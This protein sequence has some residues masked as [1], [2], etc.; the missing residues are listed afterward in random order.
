MRF[1]IFLNVFFLFINTNLF[2]EEVWF[3]SGSDNSSDKYFSQNQINKNNIHLLV[4]EWEFHS[5]DVGDN[6]ANPIL[7]GKYLITVGVNSGSVIAIDPSNGQLQWKRTLPGYPG[8]RGMTSLANTVF[9]PTHDGI[10]ALDS[11]SGEIDKKYGNSGQFGHEVSLLPPVIIDNTII[12][13]NL[14]SVQSFDLYTGKENWKK[15]LDKDNVSP[16]IW[17]GISYDKKTNLIFIVTSNA[18]GLI[19]EDI[20]SGGYSSSL[21]SLNALNGNIV[22]QIQDIKHDLWDLDVVGA[23]IVGDVPIKGTLV[24]AV[25][26]VTKTGKVIFADAK[27]GKLIFGGNYT[28]INEGVTK[29]PTYELHIKLPENFSKTDFDPNIDISELSDENK[30]YVKFRIRNAK[31][32]H[33]VPITNDNDSVL[34]GLHGGAEWPGAA[35]N[36]PTNILIIPSNHNPWI[37]RQRFFDKNDEYSTKNFI[38]NK[39]YATK[40]LVCHGMN[41]KGWHE[42]EGLGDKYY[43]SLI[44]ISNNSQRFKN[45]SKQNF[46]SVH[47]YAKESELSS[48]NIDQNNAYKNY[49]IEKVDNYLRKLSFLPVKLMAHAKKLLHKINN[50]KINLQEVNNG[51]NNITNNEL[52]DLKQL[53]ILNDREVTKRKDLASEGFWQLLLTKE[54]LPASNPPW[55]LLTGIEMSSGKKKWEIPFGVQKMNGKLVQGDIN[56]GGILSLS[57]IFFAGGTRDK[58][59]RAY[60]VKNGKEI[61]SSELPA[62]SSSPPMTYYFKGCQHILVTATGGTF[63]GFSHADSTI[64]YKLKT[65]RYK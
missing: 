17:S 18:N 2:S 58:F 12:S 50:D 48:F 62:A 40:C 55:G 37:L 24:H 35:L 42:W 3:R 14:T 41:G 59:I 54:K 5:G 49:Q 51:I 32:G 46:L 47:R 15:L 13:A 29:Q 65:C 33:L 43:P 31:I 7:V 22:W 53:I 9:V 60:D 34:F 23:P 6:Q 63:I 61:W 21:I 28:S 44:N 27:T 56:F 38:G 36:V 8:R 64:S 19:D 10:F 11:A 1:S 26:A 52:N 20:G 16:R 4:K 30:D 45:F 57:D 25:I 39:T